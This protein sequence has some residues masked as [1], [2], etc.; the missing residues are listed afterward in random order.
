MSLAFH[1]IREASSRWTLKQGSYAPAKALCILREMSSTR[2]H[3]ALFKALQ[4]LDTAAICDA[5][6]VV[7]AKNSNAGNR[8]YKGIRLMNQR[9][10]PINVEKEESPHRIMV[11]LART[12]QCTKRN[13]FLAVFR[14]VM[15]A[16]AGDVLIV[17]TN[18][19]DR[20]VAGE[21]FCLQAAQKR[22]HGVVVDG[23]VRDS[24]YVKRM[25]PEQVR[26]Y[27]SSITPYSGSTQ[28]PGKTQV[29]VKCGDVLVNPGDII[30]G[31]N[32]GIVVA[33]VATLEALLPDAQAIYESE[34]KIKAR[35][36]AGESLN[37]MTNFE[38]YLRARLAG[39]PSSLEFKV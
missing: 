3:Q 34:A 30:C 15:E 2:D 25:L 33:D 9:I 13:D 23:P 1:Q 32:D 11:G 12:V 21:L 7:L 16:Q 6:K 35:L 27:S 31:D 37:L 39:E 29:T 8:G 28:S 5:D 4:K 14:G 20:A 19:S 22:V 10:R 17:D 18:K 24:F 36:L 26:C 38:D